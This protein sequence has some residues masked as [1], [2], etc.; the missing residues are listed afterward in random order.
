MAQYITKT[1]DSVIRGTTFQGIGFLIKTGP[2]ALHLT[3][4][5]LLSAKMEVKISGNAPAT[6][7]LTD[8]AGLTL[9][10]ASP[11]L[12]VIDSQIIDIDAFNYMYEIEVTT[13][14]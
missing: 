7:T 3:P 4:L 8:G 10:E 2:D 12:V 9:D 11:G 13:A 5:P 14:S 6:L 1:L